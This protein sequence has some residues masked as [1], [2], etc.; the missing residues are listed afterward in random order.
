[1]VLITS[2]W[3]E[4][5][6]QPQTNV[7]TDDLDKGIECT[8]GKFVDDAKLGGSVCLPEGE[9]VLQRILDKLD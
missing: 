3:F 2:C 4:T 8:I 6:C 7:L 1:M 9:K 5:L